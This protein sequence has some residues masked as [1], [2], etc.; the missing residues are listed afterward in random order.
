MWATQSIDGWNF[1]IK[2]VGS[3]GFDDCLTLQVAF[4]NAWFALR[5]SITPNRLT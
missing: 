3:T 2:A 5:C 1:Y 4:A